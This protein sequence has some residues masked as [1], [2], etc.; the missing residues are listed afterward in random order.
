MSGKDSEVTALLHDWR[1]GNREAL[2]QLIPIVYHEL[3]KLARKS[4][5]NERAGLSL[6]P[7]ALIHEAYLRLQGQ[8][9]PEWKNRSHFYGVAACLMR[10]ILVE[11][12]RSRSTAKR[13]GKE[14]MV[15]FDEATIF[16]R[17]RSEDLLSLDRALSELASFDE[18]KA[19]ILELHYFGGLGQEAVAEVLQISERTVR[20]QLKLAEAWLK[21]QLASHWKHR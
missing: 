10:Q 19:K 2:D 15:P 7:T 20:R 6:Q 11:H 12:A 8:K 4:L 21:T 1:G 9:M 3:K 17:D 16:T 18:R 13:G 5:N 14:Q